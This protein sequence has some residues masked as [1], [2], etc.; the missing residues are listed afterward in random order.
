MLTYTLFELSFPQFAPANLRYR[1]RK[2]GQVISKVIENEQ[3]HRSFSE[4]DYRERERGF[5]RSGRK[6]C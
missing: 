3:Q 2:Y 4:I 6:K 5:S 1:R